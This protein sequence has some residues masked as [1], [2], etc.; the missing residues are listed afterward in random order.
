MTRFH[1][2]TSARARQ[3]RHRQALGV[4]R[5]TEDCSWA[6]RKSWNKQSPFDCG[7]PRCGVCRRP[8]YC[9]RQ[10]HVDWTAV[11]AVF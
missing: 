11:L 4:S 8:C 1:S 7:T 9:R 5:A 3:R 2:S 6:I 10:F